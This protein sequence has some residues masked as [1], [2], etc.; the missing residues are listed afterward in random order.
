MS[1]ASDLL[2]LTSL[3]IPAKHDAS[4][5]A[6]TSAIHAVSQHPAVPPLPVVV[7]AVANCLPKAIKPV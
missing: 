7:D 6:I 3:S 5:V 4:V 2:A 1:L